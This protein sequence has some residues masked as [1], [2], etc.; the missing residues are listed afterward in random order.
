MELLA[1]LSSLRERYTYRR[2]RTVRDVWDDVQR[3]VAGTPQ[4]KQ[5][6]IRFTKFGLPPIVL[7]LAIG[8]YFAFRPVP[9]PDY[10]NADIS[11]IFNFTFL[12]SEFNRLPVEERVEL[13][14]Q[15]IQRMNSM[16]SGES[17]MLAAFAAG[18][19]GKAREQVEENTA[20]LMID[21]WDKYAIDYAAVA[22]EDRDAFLDGAMIE[23]SKTMEAM[24][25]RVRD[26]SDTDR[27]AEINRQSQR[28][29]ERMRGPGGPPP[30]A[31]GRVFGYVRD[32][33]GSR[34]T[35]AQRARAQQLMVDMTRRTR[36]DANSGRR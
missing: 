16:S 8:G 13:I 14:G 35:P 26:I 30:E 12:T 21:L 23:L 2:G 1:S 7:V 9:Q 15:L 31:M 4:Q 32:N 20:R 27:L 18:I 22:P 33:V 29:R 5:R 34:A 10:M 24:G 17:V 28:D 3:A 25:G 11:Q 19:A 36:G 6:L